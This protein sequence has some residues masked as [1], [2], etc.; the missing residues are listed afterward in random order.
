MNPTAPTCAYA[1]GDWLAGQ[2]H[3]PRCRPLMLFSGGG[4]RVWC[5]LKNWHPADVMTPM[6]E[7]GP[8]AY[9]PANRCPDYEPEPP[10]PPAAPWWLTR[11]RHG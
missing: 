5:W 9:R 1:Y 10:P 6:C 7:H 2:D 4:R 11:P 8:T 3:N